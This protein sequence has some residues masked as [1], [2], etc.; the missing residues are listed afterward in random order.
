MEFSKDAIAW[1]E[2]PVNDFARAKTFYGAIFDYEVPEMQM[3]PLQMGFLLY[4]REQQGIGG[5]LCYGDGYTPAGSKGPRV[6][7]NAGKDLNT[8]LGR[9]ER[10][11]GK[12]TMPKVEIAPG[13][14]N[15][16]FFEDTEG[17]NVGLFSME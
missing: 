1:V 8:V 9:V 12:V 17:N 6:Y 2:I 3:G 15:M 14:G 4:D 11:G 7:L 13:M 16:A 5:A 10:A